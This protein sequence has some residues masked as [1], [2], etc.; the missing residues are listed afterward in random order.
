[1]GAYFMNGA[2]AFSRVRVPHRTVHSSMR[3]QLVLSTGRRWRLI[4][5]YNEIPE[6]AGGELSFSWPVPGKD[7][8]PRNVPLIAILE[9]ITYR[10]VNDPDYPCKPRVASNPVVALLTLAPVAEA[11]V[12]GPEE[13]KAVKELLAKRAE[14]RHAEEV[15]GHPIV[16]FAMGGMSEKED[17]LKLVAGLKNLRSLDLYY[18]GNTGT[19]LKELAGLKCLQSLNL[20]QARVTNDGLKELAGLTTLRSLNLGRT[21]ISDPALQGLAALKELRN[22]NLS[23]VPDLAEDQFSDAGLKNLAGLENLEELKL[24][25]QSKITNEGMKELAALKSLRYLDLASNKVTGQGMNALAGSKNLRTLDLGGCAI[26]REFLKDIAALTGLHTLTIGSTE[27]LDANLKDL[28]GLKD[29]QCLD[30]SKCKVTEAGPRELAGLKGLKMLRLPESKATAAVLA[31]YQKVLPG[32]RIEGVTAP[33]PS[34][35][36]ADK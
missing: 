25:L 30:L 20:Y 2:A 21:R 23:G 35:V 17:Y 4:Q 9:A 6:P 7:G 26:R 27:V 12:T 36:S 13:E 15:A 10:Y 29:L 24:G 22:L 3:L 33:A 32:C 1:M 5:P 11:P 16:R 18:W 14:L 31:E 28:A 34:T 19:G 8:P